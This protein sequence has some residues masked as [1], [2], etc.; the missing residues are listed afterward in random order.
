MQSDSES[1]SCR[2]SERQFAHSCAVHLGTNCTYW[3]TTGKIS[4]TCFAEDA[5]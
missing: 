3:G 5:A 2:H 4:G 1:I